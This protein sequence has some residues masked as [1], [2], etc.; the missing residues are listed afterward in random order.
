[1]GDAYPTLAKLARKYLAVQGS[2]AALE[3]LCSSGGTAVTEKRNQIGGEKA[4]EKS[5]FCTR[6]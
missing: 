2:S 6:T 3:R 5:Y 4:A 1:M